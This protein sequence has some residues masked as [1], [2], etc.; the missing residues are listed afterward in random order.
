VPSY[1]LPE[2]AVRHADTL[3]LR[4]EVR[5]LCPVQHVPPLF[6]RLLSKA[7]AGLILIQAHL[8]TAGGIPQLQIPEGVG[9]NIHFTRGHEQDLDLIAAA[10][11]KFVR[12]DFGWASIE[13]EKGRYDWSAY[14]ELLAN[15][16][17]RG[18]RALFILDYSNPLY[19]EK[20]TSKNPITGG[21]HETIASPQHLESVKA[22]ATW[23]AA[24]ARHFKGRKVLWE[25]WNEPNIHFWSP[26][27]DVKQY[28]TLVKVT[29]A[30][31]READPEATI[32][33][34]ATST[35]DWKFLEACG[36]AGLL[37]S[38]DAVSVHPYRDYGQSPETASADY[39]K[40]RKLIE[41]HAPAGKARPPILSG[42]WG[43][44]SHAKGVSQETQ[45]AFAARQQ[46]VNLFCEVPVSIWYDWKNDGTDAAEGEHNFGTVDYN[47][48]PKPAY[49]ALK[50]LTRELS[51]YRI[52][53]RVSLASG[54][55]WI[56]RMRN[57]SGQKKLAAWTTEQPHSAEVN[58]GTSAGAKL[59]VVKSDGTELSVA[60]AEG[61]IRLELA[62]GPVYVTLAQQ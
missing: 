39:E 36:D 44:S 10:G 34:A 12:M 51:G 8:L 25:I 61:N 33:G 29:T 56:L 18:I 4:R 58:V 52:E 22:F 24:A 55:D 11:F 27:P 3:T 59:S 23:A 16:D 21:T 28:V 48:Q 30:A 32:F 14:E 20:I 9:V 26:E 37:E 49:I 40:L 47:L 35:F 54:A 31:V 15:L 17:K 19:E 60:V 46:L 50:T 38:W 7:T 43:Y 57:S 1:R 5:R 2:P 41:Q 45:A 13:R 42:E 62:A 53:S 6:T